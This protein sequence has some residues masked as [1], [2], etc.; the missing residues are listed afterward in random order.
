MKLIYRLFSGEVIGFR[1]DVPVGWVCGV[2]RK[3]IMAEAGM[4]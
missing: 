2:D 1:C 4:I 3:G